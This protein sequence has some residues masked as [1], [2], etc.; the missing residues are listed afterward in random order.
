MLKNGYA[1][2]SNSYS[3]IGEYKVITMAN[4]QNGVMDLSSYNKIKSIPEDMPDHCN[5]L[6]GD[7]LISMTGNVGRVCRVNELG[8]VQNQRVGKLVPRNEVDSDFLFAALNTSFF[9]N[10]MIES[11]QGAAQPNVGKNDI[12]NYSLIIPKTIE[13]QKA[14]AK[15]INEIEL[16]IQA[17]SSERD[18]YIALKQG[19]MQ[20]L[21]S[22]RI[23]LID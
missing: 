14:I 11:G 8:C 22:G 20:E 23:R 3:R 15:I 7:I 9:E 5:L 17:L 2:K 21:L 12:E 4:V 1:F 18:K 10:S 6:I 16:E 13:E 19:A